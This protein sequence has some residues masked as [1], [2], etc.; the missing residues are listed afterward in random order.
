MERASDAPIGLAAR[1]STGASALAGGDRLPATSVTTPPGLS[2]AVGSTALVVPTTFTSAAAPAS[3]L[4]LRPRLSDWLPPSLLDLLDALGRLVTALTPLL[5]SA[6]LFRLPG[7][8]LSG[9][10]VVV[11][12]PLLAAASRALPGAD[13]P[14]TGGRERRSA[15]ARGALVGTVV[16]TSSLPLPFRLLRSLLPSAVPRSLRLLGWS[17]LV[18]LLALLFG[19]P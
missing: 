9:R 16:G 3:L 11:T 6:P 17:P 8:L 10:L 15:T 18:P 13:R 5:A 1:P 7:L 19:L 2:L 4:P 12:S 14:V